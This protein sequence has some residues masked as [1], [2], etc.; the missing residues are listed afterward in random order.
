VFYC[1]IEE[2]RVLRDYADFL[3]EGGEC[4]G[5]DVLAV[6][7][8]AAGLDVEE[9]IQQAENRGFTTN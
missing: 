3:A 2:G 1:V 6:D 9:S 4:Y 5:A 7:E 8:D